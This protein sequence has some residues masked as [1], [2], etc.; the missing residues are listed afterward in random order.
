MSLY[1]LTSNDPLN[2]YAVENIPEKINPK[3]IMFIDVT[4]NGQPSSLKAL[5][6]SDQSLFIRDLKKEE[7]H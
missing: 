7:L 6:M 2:V 1:S 3:R 4:L 5:F